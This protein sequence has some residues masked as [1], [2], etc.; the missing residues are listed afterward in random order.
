M[1]RDPADAL[2]GLDDWLRRGLK[3]VVS[4]A[5]RRK[6]FRE[7]ARELRKRNQARITKQSGPDGQPWT[8]RKRDSQGRVRS[9]AKLLIGLRSARR[10]S[11]TSTATGAEVGYR[12]MVARLASV[13]HSGLADQVAPDG[14]T[15]KYAT[16]PLL[17]IADA[18]RAM[19]RQR[20][21]D[22]LAEAFR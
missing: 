4:P 9:T 13:H 11:L 1:T 8:P 10:M 15:V 2:A 20:L 7:L 22:H 18:D 21:L 6:L 3:A 19:I 5:D 12:G 16:R 17:G 14:P